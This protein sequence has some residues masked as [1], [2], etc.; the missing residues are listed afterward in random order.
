V[1]FCGKTMQLVSLKDFFIKLKARIPHISGKIYLLAF[2][3]ILAVA[4]FI[5]FWAAPISA[6]VDVPQ[7][8]AFAKVFH[9]YGIDF[10]RYADG[11]MDI[12]PTQG[13]GFVYPPI[14]L[15][16]LGLGLVAAPVN[17]A[18]ET[19]AESSWRLAVKTPIIAADLAIGCLLYWAIPGPKWRK[20]LFAGLW[21]LHPTAWYESGVFGQ[22]DA[23]A[24]VFLLAAV[25]LL[26][27]GKDNWAFILA[28][29]AVMTKQ[30]TFIPIVMMIAVI[31]R[32][33]N[34][35]RL[36]KNCAILAAVVVILSIPFLL[37]G[38]FFNYTKAIFAPGQW[39]GYQDPLIYAFNGF[40]SL[41]THL[42]IVRGWDTE[43]YIKYMPVLMIL[44]V[45]AA[46]LLVYFIKRSITP[47][48]AALV[49]FLVFLSFM[50]RVNYQYL[51]IYIPLALLIASRTKYRSERIIAIIIAMLPAGW[52]WL[53]D[54]SFWFNYISPAFPWVNPML[55]RLGLTRLGLPD[56]DY[57]MLAGALTCLFLAYSVCAFTRWRLSKNDKFPV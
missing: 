42:H 37:T 51:I 9:V 57:V 56:Y 6:G 34:W 2:T 18:T 4:A 55:E 46:V 23:I 26:E 49:G 13:W 25:I 16:I 3:L 43:V 15:L 14:W 27:K 33:K 28:G 19:W 24:A 40:S 30:H 36:I 11:T 39:P 35:R 44:M 54:V 20:L 8:W 38:N 41:L 10:Y 50:Y 52:L 5:R 32:D 22:F 45:I 53:M 31:A 17:I 47:A 29:L 1:G 48:Q 21:L 7:F 12:F